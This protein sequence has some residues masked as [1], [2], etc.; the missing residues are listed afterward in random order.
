MEVNHQEVTI[1]INNPVDLAQIIMEGITL[2]TEHYGRYHWSMMQSPYLA[3]YHPL[4]LPTPFWDPTHFHPHYLQ[5]AFY[6]FPLQ[7][8]TTPW[9]QPYS[10]PPHPLPILD[11][12]PAPLLSPPPSPP[13]PHHQ[14]GQ[15]MLFQE[16][17]EAAILY[18]R[19]TRPV[20]AWLDSIKVFVQKEEY[21]RKIYIR[22]PTN[23]M[24]TSFRIRPTTNP[25]LGK[26]AMLLMPTYV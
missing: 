4:Q 16:E 10:V 8:P 26:Y 21:E 22:C 12:F 5:M 3:P 9:I 25:D 2:G 20:H 24:T 13:H 17:L 18:N 11:P 7:T 23:L 19:E 15:N 1:L 14:A 6:P